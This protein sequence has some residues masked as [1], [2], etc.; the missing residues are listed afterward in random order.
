MSVSYTYVSTGSVQTCKRDVIFPSVGPVDAVVDKVQR[1]TVRPGDLI[2]YDDTPV[3]A[4]HSNPPNVG[5]VPQSDQ[6]RYLFGTYR[7]SSG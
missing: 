7:V 4:V 6:Y 1:Q 5:R 3:G 2:L